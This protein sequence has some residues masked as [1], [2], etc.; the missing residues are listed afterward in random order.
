MTIVGDNRAASTRATVQPSVIDTESELSYQSD[1][2]RV[3]LGTNEG[4]TLIHRAGKPAGT[5]S[6][7]GQQQ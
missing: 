5:R 7:F 1:L 2:F 3:V 4:R 6:M